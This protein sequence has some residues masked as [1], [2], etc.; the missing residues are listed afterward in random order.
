[1]TQSERFV[2]AENVQVEDLGGGVK[3]QILGYNHEIMVVK[4]WFEQGAEGYRHQHPH[5]QSTYVESGVFDVF[6]NGEVQR[7]KAGDG[8]YIPPEELHGAVCIEAGVLID[9]FSPVREDFL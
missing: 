2:K 8:F 1:M 9:T 4:V 6:I 7:L 3:R 5:S